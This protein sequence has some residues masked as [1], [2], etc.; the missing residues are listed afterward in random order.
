MN[1][2]QRRAA[3][4]AEAK[5]ASDLRKKRKAEYDRR[6]VAHAYITNA[7]SIITTELIAKRE[8]ARLMASLSP[9]H[10]FDPLFRDDK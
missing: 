3:T 5:R 7:L 9:N 6:E 4:R 8:D 2:R 10:R 1:S